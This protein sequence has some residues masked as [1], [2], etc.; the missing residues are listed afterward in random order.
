MTLSE[1]LR[2]NILKICSM[3]RS[4]NFYDSH[5]GYNNC[6]RCLYDSK[7]F[8]FVVWPWRQMSRSNVLKICLMTCNGKFCYIFNGVCCYF[9]Q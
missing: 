4:A 1:S 6:L 8:G 2:S 7:S 3:V 9:A 5:I